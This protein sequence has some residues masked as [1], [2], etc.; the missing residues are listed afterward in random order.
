ML[1][2]N[3]V[4]LQHANL[5][6]VSECF[7]CNKFRFFKIFFSNNISKM[8]AL[9]TY[10]KIHKV[11]PIDQKSAILNWTHIQKHVAV[12]WTFVNIQGFP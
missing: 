7:L 1:Q 5:K 4:P 12:F 8:A 11:S 10:I 3:R 2:Y 9:F 6:M